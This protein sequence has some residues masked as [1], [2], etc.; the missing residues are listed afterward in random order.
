[1]ED[2]PHFINIILSSRFSEKYLEKKLETTENIN[3]T[4]IK[5]LSNYKGSITFDNVSFSYKPDSSAIFKDLSLRV[6]PGDRIAIV[7]KSGSGK[8]TMM[9]LLL[10]FYK[11]NSGTIL[12]DGKNIKE[13]DPKDI[14]KKI[15]YI[16]QRTLLFQDTL[17][18][19]M[20]YGNTKTDEEIISFLTKYDL[21]YIFRDCNKSPNTC[22]NTMVEN[23]GT[24]ISLG[25]QK[26]IFLVRGVLKDSTVYIFDEPLSSVDPSSRM[27]VLEMI[28]NETK[29]KTLLIITHDSEVEKIVDRTIDLSNLQRKDKK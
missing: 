21:L 5:N 14:R 17:I 20:K 22:L 26:I 9:K 19:N 27:K 6:N 3:P 7:S 2:I 1:M 18:N 13:I 4:Y 28:K 11:P 10:A 24:N 15:N 25:M 23:D 16:N 29:G 12:L 8:T